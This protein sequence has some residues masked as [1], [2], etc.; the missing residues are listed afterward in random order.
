MIELAP[1]LVFGPYSMKK[2]GNPLTA[3]PRKACGS[4]TPPV[5][6]AFATDADDLEP[7]QVVA[8]FETRRQHDGVDVDGAPACGDDRC[9]GDAADGIGHEVDVGALQ[10]EVVLLA[11][12]DPLAAERVARRQRIAQLLVGDVLV[13]K[14]LG[15]C[16][17]R[18]PV[19]GWS[20]VKRRVVVLQLPQPPPLAP[21]R[22]RLLAE[23]RQLLR[24]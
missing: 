8:G 11:E 24:R 7:G 3:T 16:L 19:C 12:Q 17:D 13:Q 23:S 18:R 15:H 22:P 9:A 14:S 10:C 2:F 5:V 4:R 20:G 1:W 21:R 6:Q